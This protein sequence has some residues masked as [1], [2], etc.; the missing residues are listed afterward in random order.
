MLAK[1]K[2][3]SGCQGSMGGRRQLTA[4]RHVRTF[5]DDGNISYHDCSRGNITV[6][7]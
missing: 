5:W 4:K 6:Y 2:K 1:G 3:I 7:I